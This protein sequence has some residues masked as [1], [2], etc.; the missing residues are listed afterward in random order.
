MYFGNDPRP[1]DNKTKPIYVENDEYVINRNASRKHKNLLDYINYV[2]E[3]RFDN[4]EMGDSAINEA[5]ALNTL[6]EVG[7][8]EGYQKGGEVSLKDYAGLVGKMISGFGGEL[9]EGMYTPEGGMTEEGYAQ[10]YGLEPESMNIDTLSFSNPANYM[11]EISGKKEGSGADV[12]GTTHGTGQL[13]IERLLDTVMK[14]NIDD[15]FERLRWKTDLSKVK[16]EVSYP[17]SPVGYTEGGKIEDKRDR[18]G[19][20]SLGVKDYYAQALG[21][22]EKMDDLVGGDWDIDSRSRL[23]AAQEAGAI[24]ETQEA[25][26]ALKLIAG[27]HQ[28]GTMNVMANPNN[29]KA[30]KGYA[31]G[32]STTEDLYETFGSKLTYGADRADFAKGYGTPDVSGFLDARQSMGTRGRQDLKNI[33]QQQAGSLFQDPTAT[34]QAYQSYETGTQQALDKALE[35]SELDALSYLADVQNQGASFDEG[36]TGVHENVEAMRRTGQ[37]GAGQSGF[38]AGASTPDGQGTF[39]QYDPFS[40]NNTFTAPNGNVFNWDTNS[41]QWYEV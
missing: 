27:R 29:L 40:E 11:F 23:K 18:K 41:N 35:Q 6:S 9:P 21:D 39:P 34:T 13:P 31:Y 4:E 22:F 12:S 20:Y 3:P 25:L 32:G 14:E 37:G 7:M 36:Y 24:L 5:I 19:G 33:R 28:Q 2:D 16:E 30:V 10:K 17:S 26:E 38:S 15:P 1:G 8:H